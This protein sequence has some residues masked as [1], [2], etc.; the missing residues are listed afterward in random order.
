M[1]NTIAFE[2]GRIRREIGRLEAKIDAK[3]ALWEPLTE[4]F[5]YIMDAEGKAAAYAYGNESGQRELSEEIEALWTDFSRLEATL[6]HVAS[7]VS[8]AEVAGI[9]R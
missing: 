7:P 1:N 6:A 2:E 8:W 5:G 3:M 9:A 4:Q